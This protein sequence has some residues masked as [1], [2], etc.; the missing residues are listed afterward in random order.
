MENEK[1]RHKNMYHT[2]TTDFGNSI[3]YTSNPMYTNFKESKSNL[4]TNSKSNVFEKSY[5]IGESD[6]QKD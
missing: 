4:R 5:E 3:L 2:Y 1:K 6:E